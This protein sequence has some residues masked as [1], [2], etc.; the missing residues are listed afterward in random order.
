MKLFEISDLV[1]IEF[2]KILSDMISKMCTQFDFNLNYL[3]IK[4]SQLWYISNKISKTPGRILI[5]LKYWILHFYLMES[6]LDK[7]FGD[8]SSFSSC[9]LIFSNILWRKI[10]SSWFLDHHEKKKLCLT[11]FKKKKIWWGK[12]LLVKSFLPPSSLP[13]FSFV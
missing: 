11:H 4:M 13:S 3:K 2:S 1:G 6:R 5:I 12:K 10:L 9:L 8:I 7:R